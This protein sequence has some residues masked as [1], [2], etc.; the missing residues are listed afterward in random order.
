MRV[1]VETLAPGGSPRRFYADKR[2]VEVA[3][4]QARW[5]EP[6]QRCFHV[7]GDDG[8]DYLLRHYPAVGRWTADAKHLP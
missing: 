6:G 1:E 5:R 3:A 7:L 2:R 4:I 8:S